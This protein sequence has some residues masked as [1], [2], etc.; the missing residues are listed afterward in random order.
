[1]LKKLLNSPKLA[2]KLD[3]MIV[4]LR[5]NIENIQDYKNLNERNK[6]LNEISSDFSALK[7]QES[8]SNPS[9]SISDESLE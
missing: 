4:E 1:M 8:P 5:K 6:H 2:S 7:V 3:H 9:P